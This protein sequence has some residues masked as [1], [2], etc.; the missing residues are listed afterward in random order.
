MQPS[1]AEGAWRLGSALTSQA[2]FP[3]SEEDSKILQVLQV[4]GRVQG[5]NRI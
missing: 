1:S 5:R 3:I 2:R 4:A